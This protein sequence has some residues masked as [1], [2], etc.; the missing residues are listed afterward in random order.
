[1]RAGRIAG[2]AVETA[3]KLALSGEVDGIV[4]APPT[5]T[6]STSQDSPIPDIPSGWPTWPETLTSP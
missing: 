6:R 2:N 3:A 5:S 1:M 4:T